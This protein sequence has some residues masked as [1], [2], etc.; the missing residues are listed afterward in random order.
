M[1]ELKGVQ[2][3]GASFLYIF[4][5]LGALFKLCSLKIE[6]KMSVRSFYRYIFQHILL[7]I[8]ACNLN[9]IKLY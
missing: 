5:H 3:D 6:K 4:L 7:I 2:E 9:S 1:L 8:Y